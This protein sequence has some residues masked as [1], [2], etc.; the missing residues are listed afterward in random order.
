MHHVVRSLTFVV[1]AFLVAFTTTTKRVNTQSWEYAVIDVGALGGAQSNALA[2]DDWGFAIV[3][4]A[5]TA[6]TARHAYIGDAF[7]RPPRDL[8]T[9]GG[10]ASEATAVNNG[11]TVVGMAETASGR[12][13]AFMW[14][15]TMVDLGTLGGFASW[16][17][18]VNDQ[19]VAVG[20]AITASSARRAFI[21]RDSM[22]EI[23]LGTLYESEARDINNLDQ[24][25]GW[26]K[27]TQSSP[28]RAFLWENGVRTNLGALASGASSFAEAIN[29]H[30]VIVGRSDIDTTGNGTRAF[31]WQNGVMQA[32]PS[33]GG[34]KASAMAI[35]N[36][37]TIAG[38]SNDTQGRTRAV[39]WRNGQI[40]D[41][42]D[43]IP[44]DSGW[45]L[46]SARG[47]G[48]RDAVVGIGRLNGVPRGFFLKPPLDIE[49]RLSGHTN[50][51]DTNITN[52][53]EAGTR[54]PLGFTVS[55]TSG[56][57]LATGVVVAVT[58][59]GPFQFDTWDSNCTRD[60]QLL[61]CAVTPFDDGLGRS[62]FYHVRA[63]GPGGLTHSAT[64]SHSDTFDPD[65]SNNTA[66]Q[67][68]TAVS[69]A[70]FTLATNTVTGGQ[71]VLA[72]VALTSPS[73]PGGAGIDMTN[74][75]P[76]VATVP[77]VTT[78]PWVDNGMSR[79]FYIATQPVSSPVTVQFTATY[80]V[81]TFAQTLTV[82]PQGAAFPF[83]GAARPIP[84]IIQAEDYDGGGQNV[85]YFDTGRGNDGDAYRDDDV[86][87]QRTTDTG[88]G[89]NVGWMARTEWLQYTVNV[90][91]A[92]TY[93]L[94]LRVAA[95]GTGGR[96]HVEFGGVDK[97]GPM[98][99][100]NTGG[101]QAWRTISAPVTLA[102]GTQ[103]MR[104]MIDAAGP[105]GIVGNLNFINVASTSATPTDI[106]IYANDIDS[107]ALHGVWAKAPD[108][109]AAAGVKLQT[110]NNGFAQTTAPLAAPTHYVD[111]TFT[112]VANTP[113]KLW[114]RL[115]ALDNSKLNDAVWVQFSGA[116]ANGN[117][118]YAIGS[119]SGL[120]VNLATSSTATSLN[121]WGWANTAYWLSQ[122][123]TFTFGTGTQ[124]L[125]IQTREDGVQVDQIV[126]SPK[127]YLSSAP[128][129]PTNDTT[130]VRKP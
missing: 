22:Q 37:G 5:Q 63:T 15:G 98:N 57:F 4:S 19:N 53:H 28:A 84:G 59:G 65:P 18:G 108:P 100:P 29:D 9:L 34:L 88:G 27:A 109:S 3:G 97:T 82:M 123:T 129:G 11:G 36:D 25:V 119:T 64:I 70:S 86:D 74:S 58:I 91:T 7:N 54:L 61:T 48:A 117:P 8:G 55:H 122:H 30:G 78:V 111:V 13:H 107:T 45:V 121:N 6:S 62:V 71:S 32:L 89:Y 99:I 43:L 118:V 130:I 66:T 41:L 31:R 112:P 113:Y 102:A 2:M 128:G 115:K 33:L 68:N 101:W 12:F 83:G 120:L 49:L 38:W 124:R 21:Y 10:N 90:A 40:V 24:V 44:P 47:I 56:A 17:Y 50:D 96:V 51:L 35:N 116:R 75:H 26:L 93:R 80:G 73:P 16:G 106:V 104:V 14:Q 1:L 114:L 110:P 87:I 39:I 126:L 72:R 85:G 20:S 52:P 77:T 42:N 67:T 103:R 94:D 105:T 69:L 79:E 127:T 23:G 81:R 92:G 95:N 125:R 46:E 60:G 76:H